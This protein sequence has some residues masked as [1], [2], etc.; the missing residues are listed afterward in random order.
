M[1][2]H[3]FVFKWIEDNAE[4]DDD[5]VLTVFR[6]YTEV[7]VPFAKFEESQFFATLKCM[8]FASV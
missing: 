6:F 7:G 3:F 5:D 2:Y 4:T 1:D 8:G